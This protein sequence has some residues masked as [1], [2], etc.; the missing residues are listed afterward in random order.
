MAQIILT[1]KFK[2]P[3]ILCNCTPLDEDEEI[4]K[5]LQMFHAVGVDVNWGEDANICQN[6]ASVMA[7]MLGRISEVDSA[8]LKKKLSQVEEELNEVAAKYDEQSARITKILEGK[9]AEREQK[10][11]GA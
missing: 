8:R 3:C 7:D 1:S 10:K 4:R 6:C 9:K 5:P 2:S 11:K